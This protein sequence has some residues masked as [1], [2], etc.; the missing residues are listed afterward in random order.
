MIMRLDEYNNRGRGDEFY[1][2]YS[3]ISREMSNYD[4]SGMIVYCNCDNPETS[5]FVAYFRDNFQSS[6]IAKLMATFNSTTPFLYEFDGVHERKMPISSGLFQ[7]NLHLIGKCDV[8]ITN[9]P[10]SGGLPV[11]LIDALMTAGKGFII[12]APISIIQKPSI[13]NYVKDGRLSIGNNTIRNFDTPEGTSEKISAYWWTNLPVNK[14]LMPLTARYDER[15]YP[16]YD[17][18]N[19]IDSRTG[20]IP[21]DYDGNIGVPISFITRFNPEQFELVGVLNHPVVNGK[22]IMTR[23]IIRNKNPENMKINENKIHRIIRESV[24]KVVREGWDDDRFEYEHFTDEGNGGLEEYGMNIV[25]LIEGLN[26]S[27]SIHGLGEEV[28]QYL[29][30]KKLQW[31]IEGLI[32]VYKSGQHLANPSP[33][34]IYQ[35]Y[36]IE[37]N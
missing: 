33:Y 34:D 29:D 23:L 18:F 35:Q 5:K 2:R 30:R 8:V 6:G 15:M 37:R 22:R 31:F 11:K 26:D 3:D 25:E 4:L 9:P 12:V 17:N 24:N 28:A 10:F 19:A 21:S 36:G 27:D 20:D 7:D 32:A 14:P 16:R 1:T 13:F